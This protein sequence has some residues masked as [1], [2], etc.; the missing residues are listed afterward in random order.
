MSADNAIQ[1]FEQLDAAQQ[2][3]VVEMVRDMVNEEQ[4]KELAQL[5]E[6]L[7]PPEQDQLIDQLR[8]MTNDRPDTDGQKG[9]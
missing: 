2:I 3:A 8:D 6:K 5:A 4:L 1:L 7:T 9:G